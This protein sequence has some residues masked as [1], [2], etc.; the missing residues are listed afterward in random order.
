MKIIVNLKIPVKKKKQK[1]KKRKRKAIKSILTQS[2]RFYMYK[3][4]RRK[5]LLTMISQQS[6]GGNHFIYKRPQ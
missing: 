3:Q 2:I 6:L 4:K 1:I 5:I